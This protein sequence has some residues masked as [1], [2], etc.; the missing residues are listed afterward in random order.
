MIAILLI[1]ISLFCYNNFRLFDIWP[2]YKTVEA[3][4]KATYLAD[5]NILVELKDIHKVVDKYLKKKN[6]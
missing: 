4:L 6:Q 2:S 3:R 1:L 5:I